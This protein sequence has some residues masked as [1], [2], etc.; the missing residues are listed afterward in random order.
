MPRRARG[1]GG[2]LVAAG[3]RGSGDRQQHRQHGVVVGDGRDRGRVVVVVAS[4][5]SGV[6]VRA[7]DDAVDVAVAVVSVAS[8]LHRRRRPGHDTDRHRLLLD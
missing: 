7:V 2:G 1:V 6:A 3:A 8:G 4:V 5:E